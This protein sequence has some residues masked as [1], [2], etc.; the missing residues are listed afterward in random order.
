MFTSD[1][2]V[3]RFSF[4]K[5]KLSGS[6]VRATGLSNPLQQDCDDPT[7]AGPARLP[8]AAAVAG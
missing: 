6:S 2:Q 1:L 5:V 4:I 7:P 8:V 3:R